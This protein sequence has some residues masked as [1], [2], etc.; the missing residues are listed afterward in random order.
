MAKANWINAN[1]SATDALGVRFGLDLPA[2]AKVL[3]AYIDVSADGLIALYVNGQPTRQGSTSHTAPFHSDFGTELVPGHNL[4]ALISGAVRNFRGQGGRN[5]LAAHGVVDLDNGQRIEFNSDGKWKAG[6]VQNPGATG[7]SATAIPDPGSWPTTAFDESAWTAATVI[8]PYS[9]SKPVPS[10]D[11]TIG[12]GRYLRKVFTVK[13]P[14]ASARLYSTAFG[15]Y[16]ASINGQRVNDHQLDPGF[17]DYNTRVMVQVTDVTKLLKPGAN[18]IGALLGDGWFAGRLGWDGLYQYKTVS[19]H[20]L[21]NAQ[22]EITYA[23]GSKDIV[24]TDN[25]WKGGTG[26]VVGSDDQVGEVLDARKALP[27]D[28]ITFNDE[29]WTNATVEEHSSTALVTQ[30]GPPVRKLM[31]L[32][33]KKIMKLG[34]NW[35]VDFGQNMVGHI[36]LTARGPANTVINVTHAEM[37]NPDGS[38]YNENLRS[39]ISLDTFIMKGGAD[40]ETFEPHFTFHGFRYAQIDGYPGEL[41]ADNIRGVVVG[42]DTPTTGAWE[43]SSADLNQLYSNIRWGERGNYVSIPTDCPQRD[44]RMGWMGDAQVFAPTAALNTDVSGFFTKWTVDMDDAQTPQGA[45]SSVS[46]KGTQRQSYPVWGDAGVIIPWVM[47]NTYGDKRFLADHFDAM[48]RWVDYCQSNP[49]TMNAGVGDHLAPRATPTAL[50]DKAYFAN[51]ANILAK[52]AAILGK[53]EEAAKYSQLHDTIVAAYQTDYIGQDGSIT[54][55]GMQGF[56]AR[57]F[58]GRGGAPGAAA[59]DGSTPAAALPRTGNTQASYVFA[60]RFN[61]APENVRPAIAQRLADDITQNGHLTTGFPG[62]GFLCPV[63]TQIGRSDLAWQLLFTDTYPSWLFTVRNGATTMW[64]RWDGWTPDKGYQASSMNSFNHYSFG[65]I[66][67]WFYTGAAGIQLDPDSPG[68][69]H[70]ILAPQFTDKVT[71]VKSSIESPYGKISS[72]WHVEGD[73]MNYDVTVPPNSSAT[74]KLSVPANKVMQAGVPVKSDTD[75]TTS[76]ALAAGTYHFSFPKAAVE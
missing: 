68:Y 9:D 19:D 75:T 23:D 30:L 57:G 58:G 34:A 61:L 18:A 41:T 32:A 39:A 72:Y 33:P 56:G 60:L 4:I 20:P 51:S 67:Y 1:S 14:V 8:G 25:T 27:W 50:V 17:T 3:A 74:L 62:T 29:G 21:F 44:E 49:N 10:A 24:A 11:S 52:S 40:A 64:E 5:A 54:A 6:I 66:G 69:K 71:Y 65:A 59:A 7:P 43:S 55:P 47:Y 16:E 35:V 12:P 70:F 38:I 22:L 26:E 73:Q 13:G 46:P 28:Q 45:Y 36:R 42:S 48:A 2:N 76:V 53:T 15:V 63:L 31:E 37:L